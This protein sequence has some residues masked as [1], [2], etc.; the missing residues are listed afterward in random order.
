MREKK[1]ILLIDS[2]VLILI[3]GIMVL[4]S[5]LIFRQI[6]E[7]HHRAEIISIATDLAEEKM[8][9]T[10]GK[11]FSAIVDDELGY[12]NFEPPFQDYSYDITV[13]P[14]EDAP[15]PDDFKGIFV[16]VA[17]PQIEG[18]L[19]FTLVTRYNSD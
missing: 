13:A 8:Q 19:L 10:L 16:S 9:E 15:N 6:L 12:Q 14:I 11:V 4:P 5:L 3:L 2:V 7:Q 17:H 18:V 1:G